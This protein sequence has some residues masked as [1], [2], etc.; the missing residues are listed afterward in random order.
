[1]KDFY[2][3]KR[4]DRDEMQVDLVDVGCTVHEWGVER[5]EENPRAYVRRLYQA[6]ASVKCQ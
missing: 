1:M 2:E 3:R 5:I 4:V 6:E